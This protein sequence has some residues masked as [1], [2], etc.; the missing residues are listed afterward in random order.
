MDPWDYRIEEL[1]T[2]FN[3]YKRLREREK[4]REA[5][6]S[7]SRSDSEPWSVLG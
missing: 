2:K 7:A 1:P 3:K 6:E 4:Q 5:A